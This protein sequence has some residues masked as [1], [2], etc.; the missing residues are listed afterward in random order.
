ME[1][2]KW[3]MEIGK[4]VLFCPEGATRSGPRPRTS[5]D[6]YAP[7]NENFVLVGSREPEARSQNLRVVLKAARECKH[8]ADLFWLLASGFHIP[9]FLA[10][11]QG[12]SPWLV[13]AQ[14]LAPNG[15]IV[16]GHWAEQDNY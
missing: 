12:R 9:P 16:A 15:Q 1:N 3:K 4:F 8:C 14:V 7:R 10:G 13:L 11:Y 2:R 6:R 5:L